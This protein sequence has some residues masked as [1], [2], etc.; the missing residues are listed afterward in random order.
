MKDGVAAF[1]ATRRTGYVPLRSPSESISAQQRS[2][3]TQCARTADSP[4]P[5]RGI[6]DDFRAISRWW[7][8]RYGRISGL[9]VQILFRHLAA[10]RRRRRRRVAVVLGRRGRLRFARRDRGGSGKRAG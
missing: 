6:E 2:L 4:A 7:R 5:R 10:G 3:E 8:S 9:L 1:R